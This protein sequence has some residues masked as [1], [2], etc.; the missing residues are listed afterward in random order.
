MKYYGQNLEDKIAHEYFGDR[1]GLLFDIGA[2]SGQF[3]SNSLALINLGW[4]AHLFEPG[5]VFTELYD[6]HCDNDLVRL[7]NFGLSDKTETVNFWESESH[8]PNGTDKGL[9]STTVFSETKR[10]PNVVFHEKEVKLVSFK[11]YYK[12]I[13]SPKI[14]MVSLDTEGT[15]LLI[16]KE[17]DLEKCG[18]DL[19]IIE[20]NSIPVVGNWFTAV[21][22]EHGMKEIH[23]NA[24][25]QI[26]AR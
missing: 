3:L 9:V 24:E 11:E 5:E 7:N 16:L 23:R 6:L 26:F 17:I 15:E 10:W 20:W 4:Q 12:S 25:N 2:N 13:G 18:V 21:C 19:L 8:V 22:K 1:K 14:D